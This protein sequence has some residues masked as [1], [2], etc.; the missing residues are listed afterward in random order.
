MSVSYVTI[1]NIL[2]EMGYSLQQNRKYTESGNAGPD[3]D[4][5]FQYINNKAKEFMNNK[6]PVIGNLVRS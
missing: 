6:N 2:E 5:Q 3:R 1:G 4:A